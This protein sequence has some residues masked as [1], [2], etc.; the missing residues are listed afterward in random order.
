VDQVGGHG[1][2]FYELDC[3]SFQF[4]HGADAVAHVAKIVSSGR[5]KPLT[6]SFYM[7]FRGSNDCG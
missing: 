1:V 3:D 6:P 7:G 4:G 2:E 5:R